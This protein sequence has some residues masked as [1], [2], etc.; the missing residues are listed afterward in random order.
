MCNRHKLQLRQTR[1][2][3]NNSLSGCCSPGR[4]HK[5]DRDLHQWRLSKFG[6]T[7]PRPNSPCIFDSLLFKLNAGPGT[8]E[9]P[10]TNFCCN[11][12]L[13]CARGFLR[14]RAVILSAGRCRRRGLG[15][16]GNGCLLEVGKRR[17]LWFRGCNCL[18]LNEVFR[19]RDG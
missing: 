18:A 3:I 14:R 6:W 16:A 13:T 19:G 5:G 11:L 8:R 9:G 17:Y 4:A 7:K 1:I 15:A 12:P 10:L 2:S